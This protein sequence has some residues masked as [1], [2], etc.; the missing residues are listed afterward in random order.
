M[1][2]GIG[3]GAV[4]GGLIGCL[5]GP[6][7]AIAGAAIGGG[8]GGL[9]GEADNIDFEDPVL[10]DFAASLVAEFL[11]AYYSWQFRYSYGI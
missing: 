2:G 3:W 1:S 6:G 11:G 10:D 5:F 8:C 7:G 9:M 4:L